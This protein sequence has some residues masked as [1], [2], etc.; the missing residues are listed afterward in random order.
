MSGRLFLILFLGVASAGMASGSDP[1][2]VGVGQGVVLEGP[3]DDNP[4]PGSELDHNSDGSYE[5]G[6]AWQYGGIVAPYYGA[7]A[8]GYAVEND[9]CGLQL[10]LTTVS[11]IFSNQS[12]DAYVWDS[13]GT[14]PTNVLSITTNLHISMPAIWP[15]I[16]AHDLDINDAYTY[17][18][19]FAGY[20]G[21]WPGL[22]TGWYVAADL[23]G[24]GGMPRTNIAPG[25]G[26]PTGWQ[27]PSIV[28]GP[29]Q[30]LGIGIYSWYGIVPTHETTWGELKA[31]FR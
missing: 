31:L 27:D 23:D 26:Y 18:D 3:G 30:A 24:F 20:W 28:W 2:S 12:F 16:S 17:G 5:N 15:E 22:Y 11:G 7:F 29:T 1:A 13:D 25:I 8:E 14:N 19:I 6:Y 9:V 21:N 4:C 10:H